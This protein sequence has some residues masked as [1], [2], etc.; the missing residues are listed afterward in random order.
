MI[1]SA[2]MQ[3][4]SENAIVPGNLSGAA[5]LFW[6]EEFSRPY[7]N[8]NTPLIDRFLIYRMYWDSTSIRFTV[9]DDDIEY[10]LFTEPFQLNEESQNS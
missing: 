2:L 4:F 8:M 10:D 1:W 9:L 3:F 7:F 6:D 5:S